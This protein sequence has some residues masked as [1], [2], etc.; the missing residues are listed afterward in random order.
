MIVNPSAV[1]NLPAYKSHQ[2]QDGDAA[3]LLAGDAEMNSGLQLRDSIEDEGI[4]MEELNY[5]S[6]GGYNDL[7]SQGLNQFSMNSNWTF[8]GLAGN[9]RGDNIVSGTG[10]DIDAASDIVQNNSS[11]SEGSVRGRIEDF[12]DAVP[13]EDYVEQSEV[14][15]LDEDAQMS[16]VELHNFLGTRAQQTQHI[17]FKTSEQVAEED[18]EPATDIHVEEGEGLDPVVKMEGS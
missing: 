3:P 7:R 16:A 1:E 6:I 12:N 13:D 9:S 17:E 11:A 14:P 8:A 4:D 5:N 2:E 18:E 10:S 15:D